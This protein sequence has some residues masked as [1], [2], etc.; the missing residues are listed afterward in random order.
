MYLC[1]TVPAYAVGFVIW[2]LPAFIY[3]PLTDNIHRRYFVTL[4]LRGMGW[5]VEMS[6]L[7]VSSGWL[8]SSIC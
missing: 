8:D 6:L 2:S 3:D 4:I 5:N 1:I 7:L